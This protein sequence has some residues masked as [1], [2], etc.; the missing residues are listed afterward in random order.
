MCANVAIPDSPSTPRGPY[1]P[2]TTSGVVA[3]VLH[4][5]DSFTGYHFEARALREKVDITSLL[6]R[7]PVDYFVSHYTLIF[8]NIDR[9]NVSPFVST[10][11]SKCISKYI[12]INGCIVFSI[13]LY[14]KYPLC[15]RPICFFYQGFPRGSHGHR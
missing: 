12:D 3:V 11:F 13:K 14:Y 10:F 7:I 6:A 4:K 2:L 9:N 15:N 5:R 1:V 8:H